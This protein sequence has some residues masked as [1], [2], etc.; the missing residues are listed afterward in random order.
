MNK[1]SLLLRKIR[2]TKDL[3][4]GKIGVVFPRSSAFGKALRAI[5]RIFSYDARIRKKY[6][7]AVEPLLD[8]D[9][10][11][12]HIRRIK[13]LAESDVA[14]EKKFLIVAGTE[15]TLGLFGHVLFSFS[16]ILYALGKGMIPI[17]D[18]QNYPNIYLEQDKFDKEN[19]WEYFFKQPCGYSLGDVVNSE[20]THSLPYF[21][22]NALPFF[23]FSNQ[24]FEDENFHL[25]VTLYRNF[26]QLSDT[27][28]EYIEEEYNRIIKPDMRVIGVYCRGTDYTKMRPPGHP[29]QPEVGDVINKVKSVMLEWN[30]EYVYITTEERKIVEQFESAFPGRVL[31][32]SQMYYDDLDIDY[33]RQYVGTAKFNRDNDAYLK[34]LEY[35]SSVM[36]FSRCNSAVLGLCSG[37]MAALCI[38]GGKYEN[39]YI[40]NLGLYQ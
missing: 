34:G 37:S 30:C 13:D 27:A 29:I 17:I 1:L 26:F 9:V 10:L 3:I 6:N 4:I 7:D 16:F 2:T 40:F 5:Y 18:M 11:N 22:Q 24:L 8:I 15:Y 19:P 23:I 21:W 28:A 39:I 31:T 20:C 14:S 38:N 32:V 33:G 35:L 36:V 12:E 25:W